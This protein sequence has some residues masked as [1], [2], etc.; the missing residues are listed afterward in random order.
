MCGLADK[1]ILSGRL[2]ITN[3]RLCFYSKF[4]PK[5]V[6]FGETFIDIPKKDIKKI[7]KRFNAVIFD[8]SIS[9]TTVNGEIFFTSFFSRNEAYD[10]ICSAMEITLDE[11]LYAE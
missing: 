11:Y 5:N 7:E 10:M 2:F 3:E 1:I 4:N 8:N 6:F 9:I